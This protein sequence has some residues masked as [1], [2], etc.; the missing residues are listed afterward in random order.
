MSLLSTIQN[1]YPKISKFYR[2]YLE[3]NT[4]EYLVFFLF[5]F[6]LNI[7]TNYG[8]LVYYVLAAATTNQIVYVLLPWIKYDDIIGY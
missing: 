5:F 1:T 8:T 6:W 3:K 2:A 7:E 4:F